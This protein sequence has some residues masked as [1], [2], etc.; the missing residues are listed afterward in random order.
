MIWMSLEAETSSPSFLVKLILLVNRSLAVVFH[1]SA[2]AAFEHGAT[3]RFSA[4]RT[5]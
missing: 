2:N 3:S 1:Q 4:A 5:R